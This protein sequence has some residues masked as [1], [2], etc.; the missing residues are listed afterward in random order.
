MQSLLT[1]HV[2][3]LARLCVLLFF[4]TFGWW[5][6]RAVWQAILLFTITVVS[7][8]SD[9]VSGTKPCLLRLTS[10]WS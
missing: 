2:A 10:S 4:R 7:M 9:F 1:A 3:S 6:F 5:I 8:N